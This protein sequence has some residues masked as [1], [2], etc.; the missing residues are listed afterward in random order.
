M[1]AGA[2]GPVLRLAVKLAAGDKRLYQ[3]KKSF[4]LNYGSIL[5]Y[6]MI[7]I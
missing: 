1:E 4:V 3:G 6:K 2:A 7:K 5:A